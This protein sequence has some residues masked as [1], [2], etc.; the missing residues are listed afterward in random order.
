M[1]RK[2]RIFISS[3][4]K[5]LANERDAVRQRLVEFNFEPVNAENLGPTGRNSWERIQKEIESCNLMVLL[6]GERYGWVPDT[7]PGA[8]RKI[9]VTELEADEARRLGIPI[10]PFIKKLGYESDRTSDDAKSRDAF[11]KRIE[12]WDN[13]NFR[14]EFELASELA[15]KVGA[16]V[17][18][19]ISD[20]FQNSKMRERAETAGKL[21]EQLAP[22]RPKI[23]SEGASLPP[24][25][26]KAVRNR[27]A[28]LFAGSGISLSAGLPS[29]AVFSERLAQL[30]R[31]VEPEYFLSAAA[32]A[33]AAVATDLQNLRGRQFMADTIRTLVQPP[34]DPPPTLAHRSAVKL[35][36]QIITT[37]FDRLFE[38][39]AE[40]E[41]VPMVVVAN[42]KAPNAAIL[43]EQA[44]VKLHGDYQNPESIALTE[45]DIAMLDKDHPHLWQAV[46]KVLREKLVVVV[47]ASLRDPSI[48]RLFSEAGDRMT[49]Y[50][51]CPNVPR[52]T[53]ARLQ[54]WSLECLETPSDAFFANLTNAVA[55]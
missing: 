31:E 6:L 38:R 35:F 48:V 22:E 37:N 27:Q 15:I 21:A 26:I 13:G 10:L 20:E 2:L 43:P 23:L 45:R 41:N 4:M 25:L 53:Q 33:F 19:L 39:A 40:S 12:D 47:G 3:T 42:D 49:G 29:T 44:I 5:D 54:A 16:A 30:V 11:R 46:L 50:F 18:G 1:G 51:A 34:Q 7:G 28:V 14:Q 9:S 55:P 52:S 32:S 36:P 17:V 8:D 24:R